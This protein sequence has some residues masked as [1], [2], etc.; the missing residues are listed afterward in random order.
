[1]SRPPLTLTHSREGSLNG[2]ILSSSIKSS[3]VM[4]GTRS[5]HVLESQDL[6]T[7]YQEID[8]KLEEITTSSRQDTRT[9]KRRMLR[10]VLDATPGLILLGITFL[11]QTMPSTYMPV[12]LRQDYGIPESTSAIIISSSTFTYILSCIVSP[13]LDD[14][15]D[16]NLIMVV[17]YFIFL[18]SGIAFSFII[19]LPRYLLP[20]VGISLRALAGFSAG[21]FENILSTTLVRKFPGRIGAFSAAIETAINVGCLIG[22]ILGGALYTWTGKFSTTCLLPMCLAT[23]VFMWFVGQVSRE[24]NV[25]FKRRTYSRPNSGSE[26][27]NSSG[28]FLKVLSYWQIVLTLFLPFYGSFV[29][30]LPLTITAPYIDDAFDKGSVSAGVL[31]LVDAVGYLVFVILSGFLTDIPRFKKLALWVFA[32]CPF[33][34]AFGNLLIGPAFFLPFTPSYNWILIGFAISSS[35]FGVACGPGLRSLTA[36]WRGIQPDRDTDYSA[37]IT[38]I[39]LVTFSLGEGAGNAVGGILYDYMSYN[40]IATIFGFSLCLHGLINTIFVISAYDKPYMREVIGAKSEY[41]SAT[42]PL[43]GKRRN[44]SSESGTENELYDSTNG[45]RT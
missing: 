28:G 40:S 33:I 39:F 44:H 41:T 29:T 5:V 45:E 27:C 13:K 23:V 10:E 30:N 35:G 25:K 22:P 7:G 31:F 37:Y 43:L 11:F 20:G 9:L 42:S 24:L 6:I 2:T 21:V 3:K 12:I 17:S 38:S 36:M 32:I 14:C 4:G 16:S 34:Q 26:E 19:G 18:I 15:L 8:S 1:M